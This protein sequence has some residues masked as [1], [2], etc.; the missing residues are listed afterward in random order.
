MNRRKV[1][2]L[3]PQFIYFSPIHYHKPLGPI[4]SHSDIKQ[5]T[6]VAISISS[7]S[8]NWNLHVR[9]AHNNNYDGTS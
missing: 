1:G 5:E 3:P 4:Q 2:K 7:V 9:A 8:I 6:H